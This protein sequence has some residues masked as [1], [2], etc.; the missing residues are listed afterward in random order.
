MVAAVYPLAIPT[1]FES[2]SF[3]TADGQ[4]T[5]SMDSKGVDAKVENVFDLGSRRLL[6]YLGYGIR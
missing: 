2:T 3:L 5:P 6:N 1:L 4:Q